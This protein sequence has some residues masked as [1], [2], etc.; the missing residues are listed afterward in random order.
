MSLTGNA[1]RPAPGNFSPA[2]SSV[3]LPAR[4]VIVRFLPSRV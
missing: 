3:S 4:L 2:N 1:S